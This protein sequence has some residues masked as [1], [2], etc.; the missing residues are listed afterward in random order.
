META[1]VKTIILA[2]AISLAACTAEAQPR[3]EA[4]KAFDCTREVQLLAQYYDTLPLTVD[5]KRP[6]WDALVAAYQAGDIR[7][8]H[9]KVIEVR[10]AW[11]LL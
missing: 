6:L 5:R 11:G 4:M 10:K 2:T 7:A 3:P 8:C 9:A 1:T